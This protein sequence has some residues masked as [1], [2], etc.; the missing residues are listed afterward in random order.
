MKQTIIAL[1]LVFASISGLQAQ[2]TTTVVNPENNPPFQLSFIYPVSTSG[3][4]AIN[5]KHHV[6]IS[7]LAGATGETQGVEV[8]GFANFNKSGLQGV[9][10]AGFANYVGGDAK[11]V[12]AAGFAS[13]TLGEFTGAQLSGFATV[14]NGSTG[15]Q[16]AGFTSLNLG[17]G[18]GLQVSG[19]HNT[20]IK[21]HHGAQIAGF[22]NL[23]LKNSSGAQIAGFA[24]VAQNHKGIQIGVFNYADSLDGIA[25]GL[26][27]FSRNGYHRIEFSGNE[28][29]QSNIAFRTGNKWFYNIFNAGIHWD[30]NEPRWTLGYGVGTTLIERGKYMAQLDL[31]SQAIL[32]NDFETDYWSGLNSLRLSI[33]HRF[34]LLEIFGGAS[35]NALISE[36]P[37]MDTSFVPWV[38]FEGQEANFN[39]LVYPGFQFG[40]RI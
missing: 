24:N 12:Q 32:P 28:T 36:D 14:S 3:W 5:T 10:A 7:I 2:R 31:L 6:S 20:S 39:Y 38:G 34:E 21:G 9:Q 29:F 15:L 35:I 26:F 18:T 4:S 22:S 16:A 30:R 19:F 40:V 13:T 37:N 27:S 23:S 1:T 8:A 33:S 11:G 17:Q 25:I